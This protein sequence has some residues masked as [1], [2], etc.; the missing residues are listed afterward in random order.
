MEY[1]STR[2][3]AKASGATHYFTGKP[4]IRGH[5]ALRLTKGTCETCCKE[6]WR[7][8][9][10]KRRLKPKSEA[11]KAAG[12]RYYLRNMDLVKARAQA[13]P[14]KKKQSYRR[15]HK[16]ANP[17]I[18]KALTNARRRRL[19]DA[20][21]ACQ[22]ANDRKEICEIYASALRMKEL[23]GIDYE[24]DH[25]IPLISDVVCGLHVPWNLEI[26]TKEANLAKSNH[27]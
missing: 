1:P 6:D 25:Q 4:C 14:A 22:T 27:I 26:L 17:E 11:S 7:R 10:E 5:V 8:D 21:P 12:R 24:V 20:T 13:R 19:K 3:E 15:K 16:K 9:N 23:T 18:Y 2:S